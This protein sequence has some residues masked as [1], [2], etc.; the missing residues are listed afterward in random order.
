[1]CSVYENKLCLHMFE[2]G[3]GYCTVSIL[4]IFTEGFLNLLDKKHKMLSTVQQA[5]LENFKIKSRLHFQYVF[6]SAEALLVY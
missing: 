3:H 2:R 1:M 4:T 6:F 5:S